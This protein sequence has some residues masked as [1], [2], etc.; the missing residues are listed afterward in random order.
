[1]RWTFVKQRWSA[2]CFL[3]RF[4]LLCWSWAICNLLHEV[5]WSVGDLKIDKA[6]M[7]SPNCMYLFALFASV[8]HSVR[9]SVVLVYIVPSSFIYASFA[10]PAHCL[11]HTRKCCIHCPFKF[12]IRK[13][14]MHCPLQCS[15]CA[16]VLCA[17]R[18]SVCRINKSC[19]CLPS[20]MSCELTCSFLLRDS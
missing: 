5:S 1:M 10:Y 13:S 11:H 17:A 3:L 9:S 14:C 4:T 7:C 20:Q 19:I 6:L 8:V 12:R 16:S 2:V 18:S 15:L